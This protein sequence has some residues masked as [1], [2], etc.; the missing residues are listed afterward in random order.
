MQTLK[1]LIEMNLEGEVAPEVRERLEK[2]IRNLAEVSNNNWLKD[3]FRLVQNV[4][5]LLLF[6]NPEAM[7]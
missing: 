6:S 5:Q 3:Q 7:K 1:Q 4:E 2:D